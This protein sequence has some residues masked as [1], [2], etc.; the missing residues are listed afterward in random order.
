MSPSSMRDDAT[1]AVLLVF[2]GVQA[3]ASAGVFS[4]VHVNG[5]DQKGREIGRAHV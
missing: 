3:V 2:N 5:V 4:G 1:S